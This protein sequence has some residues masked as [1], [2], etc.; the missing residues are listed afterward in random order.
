[1]SSKGA[2]QAGWR[3]AVKSAID[4]AA[5][6][7]LSVPAAPAAAVIAVAIRLTMGGP[8]LFRQKRGGLHGRVIEVLKFRTMRGSG[9]PATDA[10]R[11]TPLGR[12]LRDTSLDEIPQL[13]NLL[14]GDVSLVGPRPLMA[15]Y[16]DRYSPQQARRHEVMPGIT[17]WAQ[18]HGRNATTWAERF[19]LDLWYVDHWSLRLDLRI[20][21]RTLWTAFRMRDTSH[22]GHVTMPEFLGDRDEREAR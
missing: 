18:I 11:I 15:E 21:F 19:E 9:S 13:V 17:G 4:R 3:K 12:F 7:V 10:E 5:A 22:P 2:R 8:V 16:L 14:R 20:L 6:L 1:M